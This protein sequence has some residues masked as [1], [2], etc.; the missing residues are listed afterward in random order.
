MY[1]T[2]LTDSSALKIHCAL[3]DDR[4]LFFLLDLHPG[5]ELMTYL[6]KRKR[7]DEPITQ[8]YA[9]SVLVAFEELHMRMIAY[10][11]LKVSAKESISAFLLGSV[12]D[13]SHCSIDCSSLKM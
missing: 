12:S 3:Q 4:Y 7:F 9:A 2:S 11:D 5:G 1:D 13:L 10:R 8:F 6:L